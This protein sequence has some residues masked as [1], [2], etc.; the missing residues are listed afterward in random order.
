MQVVDKLVVNKTGVLKGYYVVA[1]YYSKESNAKLFTQKM[2]INGFNAK[3][4]KHPVKNNYY[5]YLEVFS[6]NSD[7]QKAV[8]SKL[9]NRYNK[10]L[11]IV[12]VSSNRLVTIPI[13]P[14]EKEQNKV[15]IITLTNE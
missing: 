5:V 9:N 8:V 7:A 6:T 3:Y 4:F 1:N 15:K 13:K 12:K 2:K 10:L 14:F 11:A